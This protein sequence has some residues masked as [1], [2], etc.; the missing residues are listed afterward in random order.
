MKGILKKDIVDFCNKFDINHTKI[1]DN[2]VFDLE[3]AVKQLNSK[4]ANKEL[5]TLMKRYGYSREEPIWE[6]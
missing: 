6:K 1:E 4:K 3:M 5:G 2:I